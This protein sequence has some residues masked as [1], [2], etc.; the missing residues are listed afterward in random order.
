V[1]IPRHVLLFGGRGQLGTEIRRRWAGVEIATPTH[2]EVDIT[3]AGAVEQAIQASGA[4]LVVNCA[5]FHHVEKCES[6]PQNAFAANT[7]A[8]NVMAECCARHGIEFLTVSTDYVFD[9]TL[10]RPYTEEDEPNPLSVYAASKYAGELLVRRLQS[11]A[12]VVRT[13]G[14]YGVAASTTKG[15]TFIDRIIANARNGEELKVVSDQTVSPS[16]A[17]HLAEGLLRLLQADAPYGVY[18]M[19]NEGAVTWHEFASEALRAAGIAHPIEAVSHTSWQSKVRRPA[20]SA[21]SNAKLRA[22][23]ITMPDWRAGIR[24]YLID[25]SNV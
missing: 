21:L 23:G 9:G 5:A 25:K 4:D 6:E 1:P 12:Y 14:V 7:L 10:G 18:H 22:L 8:V 3:D 17:G 15:Y 20:Y 11:N 19:V 24:D 16:Y 13:C 2:A